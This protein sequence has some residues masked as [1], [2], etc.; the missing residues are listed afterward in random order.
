MS[1]QNTPSGERTHI[2]FFG[3]RNAGKSSLVNAV[4]GQAL[5]V[6]SATKGTTTDPVQKAMELLPLGPVWIIDTPGFDDEGELGKLRVQK[7]RQILNK[8]DIAVLVVD[9]AAGLHDWDRQ[10]LSLFRE[11][12]IPHILVYNKADLL[13]ALPPAGKNEIYVSAQTG[14]G[15][16]ALKERLAHR[17]PEEKPLPL[18]GDLLRPDDLVIL[19]TPIDAAAPKGRMI[20]PQQMLIRDVLD[21]DAYSIVTKETSLPSALA[22]AAKKPAMVITD[23]QAFAEVARDTPPDIPLTSFSI[24]MA[25]HKGFLEEA[26]RGVVA[27]DRLRDG[28]TVLISEGCTHHRQC[29]DI[30]SVKLPAWLAKHTGKQLQIQLSSGTEFPADLSPYALVIHCGGCMLNAREL[31]HRMQCAVRQQVPVTNYGTAIAYMKGIL[32]RSL[33]PI[34]DVAEIYRTERKNLQKD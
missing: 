30:G 15:I 34:P 32:A 4:T 22:A 6:V 31:R 17:I 23:S 25:R 7:A 11:K 18:V 16:P 8:T 29:G 13:P 10:L 1:L 24:L 12:A 28:D 3:R 9:A 5:S 21:A 33:S 14:A 2:G 27:I 20:L 19:V 26:V